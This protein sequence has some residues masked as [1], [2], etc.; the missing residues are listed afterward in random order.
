MSDLSICRSALIIFLLIGSCAHASCPTWPTEQRFQVNGAEVT[1]KQTGLVWARC[2][3]G[4]EWN[5]QSCVGGD[6]KMTHEEAL[7]YASGLSGWR[8]PNVKELASIA[9]RGCPV[10]AIDKAAFPGIRGYEFWSSTPSLARN[11]SAWRVS[12]WFGD[13]SPANRRDRYYVQL[14]RTNP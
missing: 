10:E 8:L 1:D 13:A 7:K 2:K 11:G 12:F 4:H 9:D 3:V 14:V 5:G 6:P